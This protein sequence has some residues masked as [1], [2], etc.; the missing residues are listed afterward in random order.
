[1]DGLFLELSNSSSNILGGK[2]LAGLVTG[3][4]VSWFDAR[5]IFS[6][7]VFTADSKGN[8]KAASSARNHL[9]F[10]NEHLCG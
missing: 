6:Q 1:M 9:A 2:C 3:S 4:F 7:E 8:H 5:S 10:Y